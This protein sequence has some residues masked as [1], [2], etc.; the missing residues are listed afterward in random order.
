[1]RECQFRCIFLQHETHSRQFA[2]FRITGE[3]ENIV[4]N[5]FLL[6]LALS[7]EKHDGAKQF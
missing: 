3:I 2:V 5:T 7:I 1:M 4:L 6:E